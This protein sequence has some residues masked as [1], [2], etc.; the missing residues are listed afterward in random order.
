M[1]NSEKEVLLRNNLEFLILKIDTTN[2]KIRYNN[3]QKIRTKYIITVI[4]LTQEQ[5]E[6]IEE[7]GIQ[8]D[9]L[10]DAWIDIDS[11][12]DTRHNTRRETDKK[13]ESKD[14]KKG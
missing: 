2:I 11:M 12:I 9:N 1:L 7:Q 13:K 8:V 4:V 6:M 10:E 3:K 5:V 14:T